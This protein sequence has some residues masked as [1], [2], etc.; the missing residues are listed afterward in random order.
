MATELR[1]A[2]RL[3]R[4]KNIPNEIHASFTGSN[5]KH[6][7]P[8]LH[9]KVQAESTGDIQSYFISFVED[10]TVI[11][12][13]TIPEGISILA[14]ALKLALRFRWE[15]LENKRYQ[16]HVMCDEEA[17]ELRMSIDRI[18]IEGVSAG[19]MDKALLKS[20]FELE[21]DTRQIDAMFDHWFKLL[22]DQG[23]G[24][25]DDALRNRNA[26]AAADILKEL[27]PLNKEFLKMVSRRFSEVMN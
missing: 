25:L 26:L 12:R 10:I 6:Y 4:D 18:M 5:N 19:L 27:S 14:A 22:N 7:R 20:Q 24:L 21:S 16:D 8:I 17:D 2:I 15:I 13:D 3:A 1:R 9:A 11:D 23:T